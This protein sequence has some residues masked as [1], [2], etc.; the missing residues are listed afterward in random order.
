MKPKRLSFIPDTP[1]TGEQGFPEMDNNNYYI[2][3]NAPAKT[4]APILAKLEAAFEKAMQ[5]KELRSKIEQLDIQPEFVNS[6]DLQT[7]LE[8]QVRKWETVIKKA[9]VVTK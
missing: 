9:N 5:D 4:P 3:Y 6:R 8:S 1:T 2:N 7:W